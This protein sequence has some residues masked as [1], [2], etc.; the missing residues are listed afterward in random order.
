MATPRKEEA[1]QSCNLKYD[2]SSIPKYILELLTKLQNQ[3]YQRATL[4][5]KV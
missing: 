1:F 3:Y 4:M 2:V 5:T